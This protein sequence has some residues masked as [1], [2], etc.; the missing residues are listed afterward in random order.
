MANCLNLYFST[1]G[2][3]LAEANSHT[4]QSD[5]ASLRIDNMPELPDLSINKNKVKDTIRKKVKPGRSGGHDN[6]F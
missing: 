3:K 6:V 4:L 5:N 2:E 1:V